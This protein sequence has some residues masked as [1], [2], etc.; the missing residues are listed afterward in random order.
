MKYQTKDPSADNYDKKCKVPL[1]FRQSTLDK[2]N[3]MRG[4]FSLT[5]YLTM[6]VDA[7]AARNAKR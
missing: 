7:E 4:S 2:I 5:R 1:G 6:L 3:E